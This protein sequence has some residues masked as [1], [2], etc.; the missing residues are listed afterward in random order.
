MKTNERFINAVCN[1]NI[2]LVVNVYSKKY[3]SLN[4]ILFIL[5]IIIKNK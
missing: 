4:F 5:F 2:D 1:C 3:E